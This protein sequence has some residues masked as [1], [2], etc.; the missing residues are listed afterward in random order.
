MTA[1]TSARLTEIRDYYASAQEVIASPVLFRHYEIIDRLKT[2][3]QAVPDLLA[4]IER[5]QNWKDGAVEVIAGLQEVGRAL[6]V[7]LG[8]RITSRTTV[9]R[10]LDLR[11]ERDAAHATITAIRELH[12]EL[13]IY[14]WAEECTDAGHEHQPAS[15]GGDLCMDE[16]TGE[17]VCE[18]CHDSG[19]EA[20][21][22]PCQTVRALTPP[23]PTTSQETP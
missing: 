16:P 3:T 20:V 8:E 19:G 4:E 17:V 1:L 9:D 11:N 6:G 18:R 21:A 15:D 14:V 12:R 23:T 7:D 22:Y 13:P 5:L 10:A 2:A